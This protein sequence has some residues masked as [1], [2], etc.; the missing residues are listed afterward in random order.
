MT[1]GFFEQGRE[2]G[3][4]EGR[5]SGQLELLKAQLEKK[6]GNLPERFVNRL[7]TSD[8]E[9]LVSVGVNAMAATTLDELGLD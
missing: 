8:E 6:F 9:K 2:K 3:R 1:K 4:S 7:N 5:H